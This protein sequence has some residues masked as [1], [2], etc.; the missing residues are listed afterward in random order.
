MIDDFPNNLKDFI[1]RYIESIAQMEALFML[2]LDEERR[3]TC[4]EVARGLYVSIDM[5]EAILRDLVRRG[6]LVRESDGIV[7]FRYQKNSPELDLQ[8]EQL[9]DVYKHRRVAVITEIYSRP[10][11]KVQTFADAFLLR[12]D[13]KT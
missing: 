13:E 8:I 11:N 4:E 7:T 2:R 5:C 12:R 1:A 10:V 3:W 6:F 9:A